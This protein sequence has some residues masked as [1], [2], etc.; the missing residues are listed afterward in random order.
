MT[1][2]PGQRFGP[3]VIIERIGAG[4]M[5]EVYRAVDSRL[6]RPVALKI[7]TASMAAGTDG[8]QRFD[9]EA[10]AISRL[11]HPNICTLFDVGREGSRDF[12]VMELLEGE[13]LQARLVRGPLRVDEAVARGIEIADALAAAHALGILHRDLKPGNVILTASG[14]KLLDFGL[15]KFAAGQTA[16]DTATDVGTVL[17]TVGYMSPEQARGLAVGTATDQFSFGAILYEMLTGA[18]AFSRPTAVDTLSAILHDDPASVTSLAPQTPQPLTWLIE[19]CLSKDPARRYASSSDLVHDLRAIRDRLH[20]AP[21]PA[22]EAPAYRPPEP[23]TP[24]VGRGRE[25]AAVRE[26]LEEPHV[27]ILTLTGPGGS[28]KTR[29]ALQVVSELAAEGAITAFV[30][31]GALAGP[32][33]IVPA[34]VTAL[35]VTDTSARAP[36]DAVAAELRDARVKLVVL[37][38]FEQLLPEAAEVVSRL[39]AACP[40]LTLL[41]TSR[42]VLRVYGE[43]ELEVPPLELPDRRTAGADAL[44]RSAA[45]EL[46]AQRAAAV[47]P[48]FAATR[49][50]AAVLAEICARLDALPLAIELAAARMKL[51]TPAAMLQRLESRLELLTSRAQDVPERHQTLRA[52]IEW[53]H[54]LLAPAEQKLFRRLSVFVGGAALDAVE[55]V[56]DTR[57]DL[58]L[59]TLEGV[60]SLVDK[61]LLGQREGPHGDVRF[62]MLETIREYARERLEESGE[63]DEIRRAHAAYGIVLVE[64]SEA[65]DGREESRFEHF[66]TELDN[67]RAALKYLIGARDSAWALRLGLGLFQY[68]ESRDHAG[69]GAEWLQAIL[70]IPPRARTRERGIASM[71]LGA[72]LAPRGDYDRALRAVDESVAIHRELGD[73]AGEA[74]AVNAR[75]VIERRRGDYAQARTSFEAA[76][77]RWRSCGGAGAAGLGGSLTNLA[78]V[79][80]ELGDHAG[81]LAC[82]DEVVGVRPEGSDRV[83][84]GFS[85]SSKADVLRDMGD[86][87][88]AQAACE[89]ALL[90]FREEEYLHGVG[91]A[92]SDL[93]RIAVERGSPE[94]A[95]ALYRDALDVYRRINHRRGL[96]QVFEALAVR[97]E[98][99]GRP[100]RA[101]K[102]AGAAAALRQE[103]K[104]VASAAERSRVDPC[105]QRS[106]TSLGAAGGTAAWME[107]W[108]APV[109]HIADYAVQDED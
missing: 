92:L 55:A 1:T 79:L 59:D 54:S 48:G 32:A 77:E 71:Y 27:R 104:I 91:R 15:A 13:T 82:L 42:T 68:W 33:L 47:K 3:Y 44:A 49:E 8:R 35:G 9:R 51:L 107:G 94:A 80:N 75:G 24:L 81:A 22:R 43:H 18:R 53:S 5:G 52:T 106:R 84:L 7:L 78:T 65:G 37:D 10:R 36:L 103:A 30:P 34:L 56:G 16:A 85:I 46:F 57:G 76:V 86:L 58:G 89:E 62:H 73:V 83:G 41:V 14:A 66:E 97:A 11:T 25:V 60:S 90:I 105:V 69:E 6:E 17:G 29:I 12:L 100:R 31:L 93:A 39:A 67:F 23:R 38:N 50:N 72:L 26:R 45:V 70:E 20:E 102:L 98:A 19:R 64:E 108:T 87:D 2:V 74:A 99:V 109:E 40:S 88:R 61:S 4:G 96:M 28:G 95:H 63:A 21:R 101:L